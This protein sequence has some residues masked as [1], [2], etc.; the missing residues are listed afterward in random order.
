MGTVLPALAPHVRFTL[1]GSDRT[2]GFVIGN[3]SVVAL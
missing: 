1:G 2:I 3:F